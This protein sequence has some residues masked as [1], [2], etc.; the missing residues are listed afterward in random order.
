MKDYYR[1]L[2]VHLEA[3][4][5]VI[6]AAYKRL[7][8]KYHPDVLSPELRED[9]KVLQ[10]AKEINEAYGILGNPV[11][12]AEYDKKVKQQ[13]RVKNT[14]AST[15]SAQVRARAQERSFLYVR[16]GQ[17]KEIFKALL[18]RDKNATT[19]Y[20]VVGFTPVPIL[21]VPEKSSILKKAR[22]LFNR[23]NSRSL[24][25][26]Y[27]FVELDTLTDDGIHKR[28]NKPDFTM[29]EI[30]WGWHTC[31]ACAGSIQNK[32]GTLATWIGCSKCGRIRCAGGVEETKRSTFS[33]CPWCGKRNKITRSVKLG[34]KDR[35]QLHGLEKDQDTIETT[36][37]LLENS[38]TTELLEKGNE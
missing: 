36:D 1:I 10:K 19:P 2:Q 31:P 35:L 12:R 5:D 30:D 14:S 21:P 26:T 18:V 15:K 7:M 24:A 22:R 4:T 33:T 29:G 37:E 17:T 28:L 16:C 38:P 9:P 23:N 3:E 25:K 13:K 6:T 11:K 32:N 34:S 27:N 20:K 8:R